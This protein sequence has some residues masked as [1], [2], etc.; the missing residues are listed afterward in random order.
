MD[1][2]HLK[3][4]ALHIDTRLG[5]VNFSASSG[6]IDRFEG[7]YLIVYRTLPGESRIVEPETVDDWENN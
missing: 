4:K 1:G 7:R 3:E 2:S 5:I 6:W